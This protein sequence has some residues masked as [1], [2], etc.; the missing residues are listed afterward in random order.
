MEIISMANS[1][2]LLAGDRIGEVSVSANGQ[3]TFT[4]DADLAQKLNNPT[5]FHLDYFINNGLEEFEDDRATITV[6][7]FPVAEG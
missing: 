7:V 1:S 2:G 6:I 4:A 3:L 5:L